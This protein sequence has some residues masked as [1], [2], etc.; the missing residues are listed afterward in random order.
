[1]AQR[2]AGLQARF[3]HDAPPLPPALEWIDPSLVQG[4]A[5]P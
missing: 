2:L 4:A 1:V 3:R 5:R